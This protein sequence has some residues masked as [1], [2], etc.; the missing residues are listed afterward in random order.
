MKK[1]TRS[2]SSSP[3][4]Q[5]PSSKKGFKP[6]KRRT[7]GHPKYCPN[8]YD[9]LVGTKYRSVPCGSKDCSKTCLTKWGFQTAKAAC[10]GIKKAGF[11]RDCFYLLNFKVPR[12]KWGKLDELKKPFYKSLRGSDIRFMGFDHAHPSGPHVHC[13]LYLEQDGL[14]KTEDLAGWVRDF[15]K[16]KKITLKNLHWEGVR[17]IEDTIHYCAQASRH[18]DKMFLLPPGTRFA[19]SRFPDLFGKGV[20]RKG[21]WSESRRSYLAE[22]EALAMKAP[23][24]T[25]KWTPERFLG[26]KEEMPHVSTPVL[27]WEAEPFFGDSTAKR[28]WPI[29][30]ELAFSPDFDTSCLGKVPLMLYRSAA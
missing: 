6:H 26:K 17:N 14:E 7:R 11:K 3:Q 9:L 19:M 25:L 29:D 28:L 24:Q 15:A 4:P 16:K 22:Q 27:E 18:L 20:T 13:I 30:R 2:K 8:R 5:S 21:L 12:G 10:L 1:Y 23:L